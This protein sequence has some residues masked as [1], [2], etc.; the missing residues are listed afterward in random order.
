MG[1]ATRSEAGPSSTGGGSASCA[2]GGTNG[3]R[4]S[5]FV[6]KSAELLAAEAAAHERLTRLGL[7]GG[8]S[9]G[10]VCASGSGGGS[11]SGAGSSSTGS[12]ADDGHHRSES[13]TRGP[14]TNQSLAGARRRNEIPAHLLRELPTLASRVGGGSSSP[15]ASNASA[16][17]SGGSGGG[18][19][20][21][22]PGGVDGAALAAQLQQ[23]VEV[24]AFDRIRAAFPPASME[25]RMFHELANVSAVPE[26]AEGRR[27][28]VQETFGSGVPLKATAA[29]ACCICLEKMS[30]GQQGMTLVCGHL[31][32][33]ACILEWLGRKEFCPLCK[34][35]VS[36]IS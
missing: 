32:H 13:S 22:P 33:E 2:A 31:F 36:S 14:L 12:G 30:Q 17:L 28:R 15:R 24:A 5:R 26:G 8:A 20:G 25:R 3:S 21:G 34:T 29:E 35:K 7:I 11:S 27:R 4:P 1:R 6:C 18:H 16:A 10:S 23:R 19:G 9:S